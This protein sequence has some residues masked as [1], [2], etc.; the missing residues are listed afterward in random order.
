MSTDDFP[1]LISES[2]NTARKIS[3]GIDGREVYISHRWILETD[4]L[5]NEMLRICDYET[6][7]EIPYDSLDSHEQD[8]VD[9]A[10]HEHMAM[11]KEGQ[12]HSMLCDDSTATMTA[13]R[14]IED[15]LT[16]R[17]C[18]EDV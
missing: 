9:I 10:V 12:C 6:E 15:L 1:Y 5:R 7:E 2:D 16:R 13:V 17:K 8:D 11:E 3:I 4:I 14:I 18:N